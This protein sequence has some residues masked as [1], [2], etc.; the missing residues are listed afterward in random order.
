[1]AIFVWIYSYES[2]YTCFLNPF[3]FRKDVLTTFMHQFF[4]DFSQLPLCPVNF[5]PFK[6][7][8]LMNW[9]LKNS[10]KEVSLVF[11]SGC[12]CTG[13][14]WSSWICLSIWT[15]WLIAGLVFV[16]AKVGWG[17]T[18]TPF[19]SGFWRTSSYNRSSNFSEANNYIFSYLSA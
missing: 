14:Y 2:I 10:L 9:V 1:M 5:A 7:P 18:F 13:D 16:L 11:C 4:V 19:I 17:H 6:S 12:E 15:V 8:V 3:I